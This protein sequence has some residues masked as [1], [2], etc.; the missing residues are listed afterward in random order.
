M[1]ISQ[2]QDSR[3]S[4]TWVP[5]L[6]GLFSSA[7]LEEVESDVRDAAPHLAIAM[8]ECN[9]VIHELIARK[10]QNEQVA[11]GIKELLPE[12][13]SETRDGSCWALTRWTVTGRKPM[14]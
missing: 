8:H 9:L 3:L 12:V 10:S 1:Q 7:G 5:K 6:P 14:A 2:P 13:A 11:Q 4:P